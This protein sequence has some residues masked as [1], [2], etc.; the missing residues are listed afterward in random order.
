MTNKNNTTRIEDLQHNV[1][2]FVNKFEYCPEFDG[3][4]LHLL[5]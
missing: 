1:P 5:K 2:S 3:F 4:L